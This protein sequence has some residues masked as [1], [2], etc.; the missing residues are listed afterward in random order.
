MLSDCCRV[1][2]ASYQVFPL[3]IND[4][5]TG[6][7][8]MVVD[9]EHPVA[10]PHGW[11]SDST[12]NHSTTMGNNVIAHENFEGKEKWRNNYRPESIKQDQLFFDY[13]VDFDRD[14]ATYID[15]AITNLF[16]WNNVLHDLFYVYG[17]N[18]VAGNFQESNF[19]Q[20]GK[21]GDP[22]IANAQDGSGYNNANFATPPDGKHGKMRMY[23]WDTVSPMRDGDLEGDIV[24]HEYSHGVTNRLT[25]GP[26]NVGCLGIYLFICRL[27][28]SLQAG[29][30][31][32]V[33]EKAGMFICF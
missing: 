10:S 3:G 18:E 19:G 31:Q 5:D 12:A 32:G 7:R 14:P 9:P 25:G 17:F 13:A 1:S 6:T 21:D 27:C 23:V 29:L 30:S 11:H 4:P 26:H 24:I 16:Y 22:V 20:G 2:D 28:L 33:W 8:R 15:A